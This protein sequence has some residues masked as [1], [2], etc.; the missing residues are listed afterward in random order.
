M[1]PNNPLTPIT[2]TSGYYARS[3]RR[4]LSHQPSG[5]LPLA[6]PTLAL[7]GQAF[8]DEIVLAGFR[9]TRPVSDTRAF[10]RIEHE[11]MDA[12]ELYEDQGWLDDPESFHGTPPALD[13]VAV[14]PARSGRIGYERVA[15]ESGYEPHPGEPGRRRWLSYSANASARAW[16]LR[17]DETRP[18]LVC[19]HGTAMGRPALDL[20]LFRARWLHEE[21]GLNVILPV[22]PLHG[23]RGRD[24]PKGVGFPGEDMLDNVHAAA[25]S[26]WDIRRVLAWL[27][28]HE[29]ASRIGLTSISLGG[30]LTAM[31]AS[32]EDDLTCAILGVPVADLVDLVERH[33][34]LA[35]GDQ[36]LR[37]VGLARRLG[38]VVSPLAMTPRVRPEGRFIYAGLADR[39]VHPRQQVTRLWEHWGRPEI[40]WYPGGHTG[41]FRSRPVQEFVELALRQSGLVERGDR[42]DTGG[43]Q[44]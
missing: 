32:L 27:R 14:R 5:D 36:R 8:R 38:R 33:S 28:V 10:V 25:Q 13:Q 1:D 43:A 19:V 42:P 34:G 15:F 7:A 16:M 44:A 12:V 40:T 2:R 35:P 3:W 29:G 41:F 21:L 30:Y 37:G 23:P 18:W 22:L 39:L 9:L 31:V 26:V 20:T 24:L 11:V 6:R 17:H 4:Y